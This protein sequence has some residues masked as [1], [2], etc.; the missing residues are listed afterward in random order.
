MNDVAK[1]L[2]KDEVKQK[3]FD[4]C[5]AMIMHPNSITDALNQAGVSRSTYY[6]WK[7]EDKTFGV[8]LDHWNDARLDFVEDMLFKRIADGSDPMIKFYLETKGKDRGYD[9]IRKTETTLTTNNVIS[10]PA[11]DAEDWDS[12]ASL[13]QKALGSDAELTIEVKP[14]E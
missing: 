7:A 2:T 12:I 1:R 6:K 9:K 4:V 11:I 13:Q 5:N 3:K 14:N 8:S 10:V